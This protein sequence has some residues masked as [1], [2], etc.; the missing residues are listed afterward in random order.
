MTTEQ[1]MSR[2]EMREA[3]FQVLFAGAG[4]TETD[5]ALVYQEVLPEDVQPPVYLT[6]LVDGVLANQ[7]ALDTAITSKLKAGWQLSRLAKADLI[8]LRLGLYEIQFEP[9]L[10][11]KV[12]VNEAIEL[13]KR[14]SDEQA[15][16]F[17]NGILG[18]FVAHANA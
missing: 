7:D 1:T 8:A 17:V 2:H 15:A 16:K 12:A 11:D 6:G 18:H 5:R 10:P 4:T 13:T 14:Y 3:A 9:D